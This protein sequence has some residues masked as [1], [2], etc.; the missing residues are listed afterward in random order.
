MANGK[1]ENAINVVGGGVGKGRGVSRWWGGVNKTACQSEFKIIIAHN[2][3]RS[4]Y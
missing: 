1:R 3:V 2:A 4:V